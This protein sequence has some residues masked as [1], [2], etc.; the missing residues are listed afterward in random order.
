[1]L[2]IRNEFAMVEVDRD[3]SAKGARLKIRDVQTGAEIY[4]DSL[5]LEA[6]TRLC[7]KDF[8]HR[9]MH[10]HTDFDL[11]Y[12]EN[13]SLLLDLRILGRTVGSVITGRGAY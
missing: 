11:Y 7:H 13:Y 1:M 10:Q 8:A 2:I 5:E 4:L 9:P 3:D 12:L 6:L